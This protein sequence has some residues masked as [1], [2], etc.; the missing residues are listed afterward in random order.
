MT[1]LSTSHGIVRALTASART[2]IALVIELAWWLAVFVWLFSGPK[3][4]PI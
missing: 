2:R 3:A 4:W 1:G